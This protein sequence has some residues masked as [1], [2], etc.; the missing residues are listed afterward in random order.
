MRE[1]FVMVL[2]FFTTKYRQWWWWFSCCSSSFPL[3]IQTANFLS[4]TNGPTTLQSSHSLWTLSLCWSF[5]FENDLTQS[6]I[7]LFVG[8]EFSNTIGT[9]FSSILEGI[10]QTK[11]NDK[12]QSYHWR[13]FRF[14][15]QRRYSTTFRHYHHSTISLYLKITQSHNHSSHSFDSIIYHFEHLHTRN[16]KRVHFL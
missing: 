4:Q 1:E 6:I 5:N 10:A 14:Q 13:D 11:R 3:W 2:K 9:T 8:L 12:F 7:Y 16:W 15:F